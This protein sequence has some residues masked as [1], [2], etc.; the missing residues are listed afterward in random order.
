M[1]KESIAK[2]KNEIS[3]I[4]GFTLTNIN[5]ALTLGIFV[6]SGKKSEYAIHSESF[7]RFIKDDEI[8]FT[9]HDIFYEHE[10]STKELDYSK[11]ENISDFIGETQFD[12]MSLKI[13]EMKLVVTDVEVNEFG[14]ITLIFKDGY[15]F[16]CILASLEIPT[17]AKVIDSLSV[18]V[19]PRRILLSVTTKSMM[20][21]NLN[22]GLILCK[23]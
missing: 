20:R 14:D 1:N 16:T 3:K 6:F 9:Q 22:T 12:F 2:I 11:G 10:F 15:K 19:K 21:I 13:E 17:L 4:I 7:F 5:R 18:T 8:I 23:N